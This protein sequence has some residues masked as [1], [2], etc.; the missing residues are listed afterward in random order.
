MDKNLTLRDLGSMNILIPFFP[1]LTKYPWLVNLSTHNFFTYSW[2][3]QTTGYWTSSVGFHGLK[4][5]ITACRK[6]KMCAH[7]IT[8][9]KQEIIEAHEAQLIPQD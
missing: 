8:F 1:F 5:E 4:A 9:L 2:K 6:N 3:I 7:F